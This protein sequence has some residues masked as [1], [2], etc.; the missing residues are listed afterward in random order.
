M[1]SKNINKNNILHAIISLYAPSYICI[2]SNTVLNA[3]YI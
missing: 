3:E 2:Y 1:L